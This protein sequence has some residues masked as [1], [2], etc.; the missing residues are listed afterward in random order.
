MW[1]NSFALLVFFSVSF[2]RRQRFLFRP[3]F[4]SIAQRV[5]SSWTIYDITENSFYSRCT[6][7][8]YLLITVNVLFVVAHHF[9]WP[10]SS[11]FPSYISEVHLLGWDFC[12]WDRLVSNHLGSLL[13]WCML[14]VFLLPAF[15][16]QGHECQDLSSMCDGMHV[17]TD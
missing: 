10:S 15:T 12:V 9:F 17:C 3:L 8:V 13:G 11:A 14:G 6:G 5:N 7:S 4:A 2:R 16:R 1:R